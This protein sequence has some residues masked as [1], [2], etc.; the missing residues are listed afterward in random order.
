MH[1]TAVVIGAGHAGLAM[2]RLTERSIDHVVF[3]HGEVADPALAQPAAAH[4]QLAH[5]ATRS[6][7]SVSWATRRSVAVTC[8][9][10][11]LITVA[12]APASAA[13][14]D[15][16]RYCHRIPA[17]PPPASPDLS[18]L[19]R[20]VCPAALTRAVW[21]LSSVCLARSLTAPAARRVAGGSGG[22][23]SPGP[24]R[25]GCREGRQRPRE[26]CCPR[27]DVSGYRRGTRHGRC[28]V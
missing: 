11:L 7:S 28:R 1:T 26:P 19:Y 13:G 4:P 3:E 22:G 25:P 15:A 12:P 2:R 18:V 20:W 24:A 14:T 17:A 9:C 27:P 21:R 23:A 5:P 6:A 8:P 10:Q 16:D